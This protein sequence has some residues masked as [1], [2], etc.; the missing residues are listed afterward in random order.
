MKIAWKISDESLTQLNDDYYKVSSNERK[1][2][3]TPTT[4]DTPIVI[5]TRTGLTTDETE[6]LHKVMAAINKDQTQYTVC[7]DF[8]TG[9]LK[10]GQS[11]IQFGHT[12]LQMPLYTPEKADNVM[13]CW[14][15]AI[16]DIMNDN[17]KKRA[18]WECL[19]ASF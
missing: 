11:M 10:P 17:G 7:N 14:C 9:N 8:D 15:D 12:N 19:K 13:Q 3:N 5:V 18:L 4:P 2:T 1:I 16:P 6:F